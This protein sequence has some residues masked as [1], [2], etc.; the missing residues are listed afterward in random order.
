ME[1]ELKGWNLRLF[2]NLR[3]M[4]I[5]ALR[6]LVRMPNSNNNALRYSVSLELSVRT[7]DAKII[8]LYTDL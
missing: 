8:H 3:L 1:I 5:F 7:Y 2:N 6:V 4:S